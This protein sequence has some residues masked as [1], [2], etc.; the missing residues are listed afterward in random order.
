MLAI[1]LII[2]GVVLRLLPHAANFTPIA[3]IALFGGVYLKRKYALILPLAAIV[4]S[5]IAI[6]FDSLQSRLTV[7][8]SFIII[9]VIGLAIRKRKRVTTVIAGSVGGSLVFF[10]VTNFVFFYEPTMYPHTLAGVVSSYYNAIPFFRN[11]LLGDL[12][13]TGLLFGSYELVRLL[14]KR[15]ADARAVKPA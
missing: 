7:Y 4:I 9:G 13:Y 6:G 5:D 3:A 14:L 11:T 15:R 8:G 1:L 10:L 12:F 2:L